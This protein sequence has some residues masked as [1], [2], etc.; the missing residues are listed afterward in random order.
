MALFPLGILS[1]AGAGGADLDSYELIETQILGSNQASITFSNLGDYAS[2]YKHLQIRSVAKSGTSNS[3]IFLYFNADEASN[4]NWHSLVGTGSAVESGAAAPFAGIFIAGLPPSSVTG[5]NGSVC[6]ILDPYST[7]K[8]TTLRSFA[9]N[10]EGE[11]RGVVLYGGA[12]R[13]TA[14]ITSIKLGSGGGILA[15]NS[16]FSLYGIRG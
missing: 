15:A 2:T 7:T 4:Y 10:V 13:N 16:R 11:F 1:A 9:G 8:N 3:A 5:F 14:A 6:D 12:W